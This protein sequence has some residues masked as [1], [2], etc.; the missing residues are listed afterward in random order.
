MPRFLIG[1]LLL[2]GGALAGAAAIL[3]A[4]R[5]LPGE[6][7]QAGV[8]FAAFVAAIGVLALVHSFD[9]YALLAG[10]PGRQA[11]ES[12]VTQREAAERAA[13]LLDLPAGQPIQDLIYAEGKRIW[14]QSAQRGWFGFLFIGTVLG[15]FGAG[16]ALQEGRSEALSLALL[17]AGAALAGAGVFARRG[18]GVK[19]VLDL[20]AGRLQRFDASPAFLALADARLEIHEGVGQYESGGGSF[21]V[22]RIGAHWPAIGFRMPLTGFDERSQAEDAAARMAQRAGWRVE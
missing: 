22:W 16:I 21:T 12:L 13:R 18:R 9:H 6:D 14:F 5:S 10:L 17:L 15:F 2:G 11:G 3:W 19:W 4:V 7:A 1:G 8:W 20:G